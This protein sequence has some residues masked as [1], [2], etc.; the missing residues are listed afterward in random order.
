MIQPTQSALE[1]W[2]DVVQ[3]ISSFVS[4]AAIIIGGWLAWRRWGRE[5]PKSKRGLL[6][7]SVTSVRLDKQRQLVHVALTIKN[8][9]PVSIAPIEAYTLIYQI[10]PLDEKVRKKIV[11]ESLPMDET[12]TG[13]AWPDIE[14][15]DYPVKADELCIDSGEQECLHAEFIIPSSVQV[16]SVYS[17]VCMDKEDPNQGW[18]ANDV[19]TLENSARP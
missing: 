10:L 4:T 14:R 6:T 8:T 5:R 19:V 12:G 15:V 13:F 1:T 9:G 16:A 17:L 2:K 3:I 7:Q 11:D 18:D